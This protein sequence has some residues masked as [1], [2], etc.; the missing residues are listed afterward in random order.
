M[1]DRQRKETYK[2]YRHACIVSAKET[3]GIHSFI[4]TDRQT[5]NVNREIG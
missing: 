3:R 5:D 2:T 1:S 4:P